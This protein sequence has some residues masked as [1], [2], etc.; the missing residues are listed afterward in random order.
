[1]IDGRWGKRFTGWV[2]PEGKYVAGLWDWYEEHAIPVGGYV[3]LERTDN[4][5][6]VVV[7]V[8]PHRS[9]RDWVRM[10]RVEGAQLRF[11]L[12]KQL[13]SCDYDEALIFA[14]ADPAGTDELR[15][16]LHA[17][18]PSVAE[19]VDDM[20]PQLMGLS[21]RGVVHVKTIYSGINLLRRTPPGP[22]FAAVVSNPRF[23]EV[24]DGEFGMAR[25]A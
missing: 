16:K 2:V 7:D 21:T 3:I 14:E 22:V 11:Q 18:A 13:I 1:V 20:A 4:P 24:G 5:L 9:K 6:E 10:A 19:L 12:Q 23:Q 15:R 17:A 25:A 8:R